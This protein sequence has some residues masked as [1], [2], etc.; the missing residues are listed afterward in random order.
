MH[1]KPTLI[2]AVRVQSGREP[3][4]VGEHRRAP[5]QAAQPGVEGE[6]GKE[7]L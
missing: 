1:R 5:R 2:A 4:S 3:V 7:R 6:S